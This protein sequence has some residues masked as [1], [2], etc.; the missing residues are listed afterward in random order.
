[1]TGSNGS[2][3]LPPATPISPPGQPNYNWLLGLG[4]GTKRCW[5]VRIYQ[6][7]PPCRRSRTGAGS[8]TGSNGPRGSACPRMRSPQA[9][10]HKT[11]G[12]SPAP[13]ARQSVRYSPGGLAGRSAAHR[14]AEPGS[15]H[16]LGPI[17]PAGRPAG[18]PDPAEPVHPQ[19]ANWSTHLP[20]SPDR[21][22]PPAGGAP[23]PAADPPDCGPIPPGQPRRHGT[24]EKIP[25]APTSSAQRRLHDFCSGHR[26]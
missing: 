12:G 7:P 23:R 9:A 22:Q 13:C 21:A 19:A 26:L 2:P 1:M 20:A 15:T 8:S 5:P 11:A 3:H 16:N 14:G 6:Q 24:T 17:E 10:K 18:R 4:A 25:T